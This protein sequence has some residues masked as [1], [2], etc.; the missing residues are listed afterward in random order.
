MTDRNRPLLWAHALWVLAVTATAA[1]AAWAF[2]SGRPPEYV[3]EAVVVVEAQVLPNTTPVTPDIVTEKQIVS[4]GAVVRQAASRLR[5]DPGFVASGLNVS[6]PA[7]STV[8]GIQFRDRSPQ[9]ARAVAQAV[10]DAYVAYR[11]ARPSQTARATPSGPGAAQI[12]AG[13]LATLVTPA[14]VPDRPAG[15]P[16]SL[17]T[18]LGAAAGLVLGVGTA[19]LRDRLDDRIR[20]G[21][22]LER[23]LGVPVLAA[24]PAMRTDGTTAAAVM[25]HRSKGG[26]GV[27]AFRYLRAQLAAR[28]TDRAEGNG[29]RVVTIASASG[30][31]GRTTIAGN[32][33]VALAVGGARV[34]L[35]DGDLRSPDLHR[36]FGGPQAT[37]LGAVLAEDAKVAEALRPTAVV[38]LQVLVAGHEADSLADRLQLDRLGGI[39]EE[40]R[41][42]ADFVVVDSPPLDVVSDGMTLAAAADIVLFVAAVRRTRRPAVAIARRRL[43]D[44]RAPLTAAVV[45]RVPG[46][47]RRHRARGERPI[48]E[49]GADAVYPP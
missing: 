42:D 7:D 21:A 16:A 38:G 28:A 47:L 44:V 36:W 3:S 25:A 34:V 35:V 17:A 5:V 30:G 8:L 40:L 45:N 31:E 43:E 14:G 32:L 26:P 10:A 2:A 27:E 13:I 4:S 1:A 39:F 6:V 33:A 41:R 48:L 18:A 37:G 11:A 46:W 12:R 22:D 49:A 24:V 15:N 20:G 19:L 23:R 9:R 29:G